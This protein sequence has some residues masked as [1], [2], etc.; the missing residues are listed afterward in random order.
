M[1]KTFTNGRFRIYARIDQDFRLSRG[2]YCDDL[3]SCQRQKRRR[4][5]Q[6]NARENHENTGIYHNRKGKE[7]YPT[8]RDAEANRT[9]YKGDFGNFGNFGENFRKIER[10]T[11]EKQPKTI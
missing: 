7:Q 2:V 9:E 3:E 1:Q 11:K 10:Q 4:Q 5:S 8:R 6:G